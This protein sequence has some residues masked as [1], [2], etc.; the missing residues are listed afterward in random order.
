MSINVTVSGN[1]VR[2]NRGKMVTA[3][4][5]TKAEFEKR[6]LMRLEQVREQ[7]KHI[8]ENLRN[9]VKKQKANCI[10]QIE[11]E[12]E[13]Q[14][15]NWQARKLLELQNQYQEALDEI[16]LGHKD[17]VRVQE[18]EEVLDEQ[19]ESNE[20]LARVRGRAAAERLQIERNEESLRRAM[21]RQRRIFTSDMENRR[22]NAVRSG[23]KG[24]SPF[25]KKKG[26]V[27]DSDGENKIPQLEGLGE[28][29]SSSSSGGEE[30]K[31]K[32]SDGWRSTKEQPTMDT[33]KSSK[34]QQTSATMFQVPTSDKA[35][36]TILLSE[37][38]E[39]VHPTTSDFFVD[40]RISERIKR[41]AKLNPEVD[42]CDFLE[43][44]APAKTNFCTCCNCPMNHAHGKVFDSE[45]T[46]V[47]HTESTHK[48]ATSLKD[49]KIEN[50]R[51]NETII[52]DNA[53]ML[54]VGDPHFRTETEHIA[55]T[56]PQK[57]STSLEVDKTNS[58]FRIETEN[59]VPVTIPQR[60]STSLE[61]DKTKP[62]TKSDRIVTKTTTTA[63]AAPQRSAAVSEK[64]KK[65]DPTPKS[66]IPAKPKITL[67]PTKDRPVYIGT[68]PK[69]QPVQFYDHPNRYSKSYV[70]KTTP[71]DKIDD[72]EI[73]VSPNVLSEDEIRE[74]MRQRDIEAHVRGQAALE[75]E[76]VQRE[77]R[78]LLKKL[79]ALQ[80]QE[81]IFEIGTDKERYHMSKD[82]LED[83]EKRRQNRLDNAY[84]ELFVRQKPAIVTLPKRK[85]DREERPSLNLA[86]WDV[87]FDPDASNR[88]R[89]D[90]LSR[91]LS[92]LKSQKESLLKEI[93]STLSREKLTLPTKSSDDR[94]DDVKS[95][96]TDYTRTNK[97]KRTTEERPPSSS[98][99][100]IVVEEETDTRTKSTKK[101]TVIST[102]STSSPSP[103]KKPKLK[104]SRKTIVLQNTSTQ[105]TPVPEK[106]SVAT[107]PVSKTPPVSTEVCPCVKGGLDDLCEIVI[108][109][110][111]DEKPQIQVN[112]PFLGKNVRVVTEEV[113][114]SKEE[115][116]ESPK[117]STS[118]GEQ[119]I[120]SSS[121]QSTSSTTYMDPPPSARSDKGKTAKLPEE[122]M[123]RKSSTKSKLKTLEEEMSRKSTKSKPKIMEEEISRKSS[124][125]SKPKTPEE[126]TSRK[127]S[128]K[129]KTKTPEDESSRRSTQ[130][131]SEF[132]ELYRSLNSTGSDGRID[133]R[134]LTYIRKLLNMSR[135]SIDELTVSTGS[136]VSTPSHSVIETPSNNPLLQL[137]NV[138]KYFNLDAAELQKQLSYASDG[139]SKQYN[140]SESTTLTSSSSDGD[141][142]QFKS[143]I[144][145][146]DRVEDSNKKLLQYADI[147]ASCTEKINSLTAMIEK[148]RAEKKKMI[149]NSTSGSDKDLTTTS[150]K[151]LPEKK[152]KEKS[153]KDEPRK[154]L[155]HPP[156]KKDKEKSP[157]DELDKLLTIDYGYAEQLKRLSQEEIQSEK[158][159]AEEEPTDDELLGRLQKL[160]DDNKNRK[161]VHAT[162]K[163]RTVVEVKDQKV[164]QDF[165]GEPVA[166]T[167]EKKVVETTDDGKTVGTLVTRTTVRLRPTEEPKDPAPLFL[168]IPKL[169]RLE[170]PS[171]E[172]KKK[173]PPTSK[174][175]RAI[176]G[177][178][179]ELSTII[180]A[181]SQITTKVE[182]PSK[183][184]SSAG[185]KSG[186]V[187]D[188]GAGSKSQSSD[189][190]S[191]MDTMETMLISIGM[192]WAIPTL[193]KTREALAMT[194]SSS[195]SKESGEVSL[196]DFLS[197]IS[198]STSKSE[199]GSML[200]ESQGVS[201]IQVDNR[202]TSTPITNNNKE[203]PI[204]ITDSDVSSVREHSDRKDS[205][206]KFYDL[207]EESLSKSR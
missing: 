180:E 23:K 51:K 42:Y 178:A 106:Q 112:P 5:P 173:R 137:V 54:P 193:K 3:S 93:K 30:V 146:A 118:W 154:L 190:V 123:S 119:L 177:N 155:I 163:Q 171:L 29:S 176:A 187:S 166:F 125:K 20:I 158:K 55:P 65:D 145:I 188:V 37:D 87:D 31:R 111:E 26:Q 201:L 86:A 184:K 181:D 196:R 45:T 95:K 133:P 168:D 16:G 97:R 120:H 61:V 2:I 189:D 59:T 96:S 48:S 206:E 94:Q 114:A 121:S 4:D 195:G 25:K 150:Y 14:L 172:K 116:R 113:E 161:N 35:A 49:D 69:A 78:D 147:A 153:P 71:V 18:E 159:R 156:E 102:T 103:R 139:S 43:K 182:S 79:P 80:K 60:S 39:P 128:T 132:E 41:R 44:S 32:R 157:K 99:S 115:P 98:S 148:V 89:S 122:E 90:K 167:S 84:E 130:H 131:S 40:T 12:G 33:Q 1:P 53:E 66:I 46:N 72:Q 110:K 151:D 200:S 108:K 19:K 204:F 101:S 68:E 13:V 50:T 91:L 22:A 202:R 28:E 162:P 152:E 135:A 142:S 164:V 67:R 104:T 192:E 6:R 143:C 77:Y 24:K 76:K 170:A 149:E 138:M 107:S 207:N 197:K 74:K 57:S 117:K 82:R 126:E 11:K 203:G 8:A 73:V 141:R 81:R 17:A 10:T 136:E 62:T 105:T 129:S 9:K 144:E 134:L 100:D 205:T 47:V 34:E 194:S 27:F 199:E 124:A 15:K 191:E 186:S 70:P 92:N 38:P 56:I 127:L 88:S 58:R 63:K 174:G 198:S 165:G 75:K 160:L 109:I 169:P 175:M 7:S 140:T 21:P 179:H 64:K 85:D 83:L 52:P 183:S 185:S 36:Q